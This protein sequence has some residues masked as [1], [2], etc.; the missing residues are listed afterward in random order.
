MR[1]VL[2]L[3]LVAACGADPA[4]TGTLVYSEQGTQHIRLLDLASGT[5]NLIDGGQ[6][7]S[8]SIAP[9][10]Q[11]VAYEGADRI[12]KVADRAGTITP[13][14]PGGGCTG[15]PEWL[16]NSALA[17]CIG[18]ASYSGTMLLPSLDGASPRFMRGGVTV[19]PDG[20]LVA[21]V[22]AEGD[23]IVENMDGTAQRVLV[24]S[25]DPTAMYPSWMVTAFTPD[26]EGLVLFDFG[27]HPNQLD[28][29]ALA[30]GAMVTVDNTSLGYGPIANPVFRGA[31]PFS[32]DGTELVAQTSGSLIAIT[33]ATGAT[34]QLATL[35]TRVTSGGAVFVDA[36]HVLW[37]RVENHSVSDIG[38]YTMSVHVAGP[39]G[40]DVVLID[41]AQNE[42]WQSI[43]VSPAGFVAVPAA[44]LLVALDGTV[45][46]SNDT[47]RAD[48][49]LGVTPDNQG[50]IV[51][52]FDGTIRY[53]DAGGASRDLAQTPTAG[54][55][56]VVEP[57]AAYSPVAAP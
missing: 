28:I 22:N 54:G 42:L 57:Y 56:E 13:I 18:T 33:L 38:L 52:S 43:A 45:L 4:V 20:T 46:V 39:G 44:A 37:V 16:T 34:R 23:V 9:D 25:K 31:S 21:Y 6:F 5:S 3:A 50:V 11:H 19:S 47:L 12:V 15:T 24:P 2:L 51:H 36:E 14:L 29:V 26:Q 7:G 1:S 55:P 41:G 48:D 35:D 32:P 17:Y 40:S 27:V 49:V 30:D 8:V 10:A 53:V